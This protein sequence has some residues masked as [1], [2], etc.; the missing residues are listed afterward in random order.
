MHILSLENA[1]FLDDENPF[2][3]S[4]SMAEEECANTCG[5]K[6]NGKPLECRSVGAASAGCECF[7]GLLL[8]EYLKVSFKFFILL[9][10]KSK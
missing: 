5:T 7:I 6:G 2:G 8:R 1:F 10:L 3:C 4:S 9:G